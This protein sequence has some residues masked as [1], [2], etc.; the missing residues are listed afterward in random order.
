MDDSGWRLHEILNVEKYSH[1]TEKKKKEEINCTVVWS[2]SVS[3][4]SQPF[5]TLIRFRALRS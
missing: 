5:E 1:N 2:L 4:R 3:G